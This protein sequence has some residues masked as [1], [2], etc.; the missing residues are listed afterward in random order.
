MGRGKSGGSGKAQGALTSTACGE[1]RAGGEGRRRG[2]GPMRERRGP[3]A[4]ELLALLRDDA[5]HAHFRR[6]ALGLE[7]AE[8]PHELLPSLDL[9]AHLRVARRM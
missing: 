4:H 3:R 9:L 5:L 6:G 2:P 8:L 7:L 1:A